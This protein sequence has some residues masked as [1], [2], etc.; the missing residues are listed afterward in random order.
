MS[1]KKIV[2]VAMSADLLHPGH[3]NIL[4]IASGYGEVVVGLLTDSAIASYKRLP[5]MTFSQRQTVV[6]NVKNVSR[7]IPQETLDYVPNLNAIK[8]DYVVHGDDW[9]SGVQSGTRQGVID[10]LSSWGGELIEVPYTKGISSTALIGA[11]KE[12][13][14]TPD[15]RRRQLRRLLAAKPLI[16]F[17]DVHSGLTGRIAEDVIVEVGS[18]KRSFDG[19]WAG[20]LSD[21]TMRGRPDIESVDISSRM[22]VLDDIV[23]ATT[24]PIIYDGDSGGRDEH[25]AYTVRALERVGVSAVIIE[26]KI[27]NKRNSLFGLQVPQTQADIEV[28]AE[29]ILSGKRAQITDDFMLIAR[30]ESFICGADLDDALRRAEAYVAAG[31]DGIMIHSANNT[32]EQV[33]SFAEQYKKSISGKPLV[34]VPSSFS[35]VS[36]RELEQRGFNIVIYANQLLRSAFPA[37]IKTAED[38]LLNQEARSSESSMMSISDLLKYIPTID[39]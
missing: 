16:N 3:I 36:E 24:K 39:Q 37:M 22:A 28:F 4:E 10:A 23:D 5:F 8:P 20:S 31:A 38:I 15:I 29:K 17:I 34:V 2:Y 12:I 14:V 11:M 7:V 18:M 26:D 25:F 35:G 27:G 6:Q 33:F 1:D 13:G 19:M 32:P 21:A 30:I 9:K